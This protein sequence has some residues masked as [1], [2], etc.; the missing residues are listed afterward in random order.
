MEAASM[1]VYISLVLAGLG[2]VVVVVVVVVLKFYLWV[3]PIRHE[4]YL[5][6]TSCDPLPNPPILQSLIDR[7]S[8]SY[9]IFSS[10]IMCMLFLLLSQQDIQKYFIIYINFL[11]RGTS[12]IGF[13]HFNVQ[14][15]LREVVG[16][17]TWGENSVNGWEELISSSR[18]EN[19]I[20]GLI[21]FLIPSVLCRGGNMGGSGQ[22]GSGLKGSLLFLL[23]GF[24][25][26]LML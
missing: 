12:C 26:Y 5:I 6:F 17:N 8:S 22:N 18:K 15:L 2:I 1:T 20:S 9:C 3:S 4:P 14:L 10:N 21:S 23:K 24:Y 11:F 16:R 19:G 25:Y 13:H 7:I